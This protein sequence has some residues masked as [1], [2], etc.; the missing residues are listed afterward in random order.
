M[1]I[2][3]VA[4]LVVLAFAAGR[5][6]WGRQPIMLAISAAAVFWLQ[7]G[8][9]FPALNFWLPVATLVVTILSWA[10]TATAEVRSWRMNWPAV[11]ILFGVAIVFDLRRY[12]PFGQDVTEGLPALPVLVAALLAVVV[13]A[14]VLFR[15]Q[16]AA[17]FWRIAGILGIVATFVVLKSPALSWRLNDWLAT[18]RGVPVTADT[19]PLSWLGYSYLAFRLLHTIRDRQTGRLPAVTLGEYVN[20]AVF[21]PSFTSGPIDRLERFVKE[22]REP[23]PM[24]NEDWLD[25]GSRLLVGLF[26]KFVIADL[27][28]VLSI[29]DALV[30]RAQ[31]AGWLWVFLYAYA[32]RLYF[33]F[34]GYT[35]MAIGM[36][37]LL[38]VR[39]PENFA[40]PYLKP[41][42]TLFWNS[43]H[44]TLTQWFRNYVFNP[45]T[46]ALRSATWNIP[47]WVI[48]LVGQ[49]TTMI[50]IGLWHGI[51]WGFVIWGA[52]HALGL[53]IHNRWSE[54]S[55]GRMPGWTQGNRAQAALS[56]VGIFLTFNYVAV[57]WLFFTLS[58][59]AVAWLAVQRLFGF[60]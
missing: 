54:L 30:G 17:R 20:Y 7:S 26:K 59:P 8:E 2:V 11:L 51:A 58:S 21:F 57:G 18:L 13:S 14:Y 41:N 49:L 48:I 15:W 53:F 5:L 27:L 34:S 6:P 22:V 42:L 55:R 43:W 28:A 39:L 37:R 3:Q 12:L 10:L 56:A 52:W 19:L 9:P 40:A 32:L 45:L 31:G 33:D 25:A 24:T 44:I 16:G 50:L 47:V 60:A 23:L 29:N 35:D 4:V 1:T 46:R 38:G 36:G